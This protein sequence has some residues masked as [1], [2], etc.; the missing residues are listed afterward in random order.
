MPALASAARFCACLTSPD[1]PST[2]QISPDAS[3]LRYS[4]EWNLRDVRPDLGQKLRGLV[5]IGLLLGIRIELEIVQRRRNDVVGG[6]QHVHAAGLELRKLLRLEDDVPAGHR[7]AD[8]PETPS[9]SLA[10]L[11]L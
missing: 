9:I 3:A 4:D 6:V 8:G 11:T 1:Q 7:I 10:F 5:E 2:R